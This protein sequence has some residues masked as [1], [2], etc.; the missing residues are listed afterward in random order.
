MWDGALVTIVAAVWVGGLAWAAQA[1]EQSFWTLLVT[2]FA[3]PPPVLEGHDRLRGVCPP[4]A[5]LGGLV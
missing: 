5:Y 4:Y 2:G 1:T 3:I